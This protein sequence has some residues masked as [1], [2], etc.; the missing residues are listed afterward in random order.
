[1]TDKKTDIRAGCSI[2]SA[3]VPVETSCKKCGSV[4][5]MWSDDEEVTCGNC[6]AVVKQED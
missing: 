5:E 1:M 6:G 4:I 3:P 2:K